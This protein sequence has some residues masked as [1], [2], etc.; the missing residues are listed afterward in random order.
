MITLTV[1]DNA[2]P[3]LQALARDF[4]REFP[5]AMKTLG[6]SLRK[7]IARELTAG[8]P[9]GK[10]LAPLH[11]N[12]LAL[13]R[14]FK[15]GKERQFGGMLV[16]VIRYEWD[17]KSL[18]VG[19]LDSQTPGISRAAVRF[20][21][22]ITRAITPRERRLRRILGIEQEKAY[23]KPE[24]QAMSPYVSDPKIGD[25]ATTIVAKAIKGIIQ[26]RAKRGK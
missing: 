13:R 20:Q 14:Y 18:R 24:R 7:R 17:G 8:S 9:A 16:N 1:K 10:A 25:E 15:N 3:L 12:T 19:W 11:Q 23:V 2:A 22:F 5:R 4:P 21:K 6:M 26:S